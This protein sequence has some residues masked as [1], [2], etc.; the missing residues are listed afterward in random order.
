MSRPTMTLSAWISTA[1]TPRL[2]ASGTPYAI[3]LRVIARS[4][5]A[6]TGSPAQTK[7]STPV[8]TELATWPAARPTAPA[9][10]AARPIATAAFATMPAMF[11]LM[12]RSWR[13]VRSRYALRT[14]VKP[15]IRM[16]TVNSR[17]TGVASGMPASSANAGAANQK[18]T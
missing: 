12:T 8:V 13:N 16:V 7:V 17:M 5:P 1:S 2:A 4:R 15:S 10:A 6:R 14:A 9:P 18:P 3:S 11:A